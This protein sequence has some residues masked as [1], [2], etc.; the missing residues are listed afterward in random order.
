M[1]YPEPF[2]RPDSSYYWFEY[3]TAD[4]SRKRRSTRRKKKGEARDEIRRFIDSRARR[5]LS[6]PLGKYAEPFFDWDRCPRIKRLRQEGKTVGQSYAVNQRLFVTRDLSGDEIAYI[7][8][9]E[10]TRGDVLRYRDRLIDTYGYSVVVNNAIAALRAILKEAV[11]LEY[12]PTDPTTGITPIAVRKRTKHVLT[13]EQARTLFR[14]P[15]GLF[16]DDT[17][18]DMAL[19]MLTCG[20]RTQEVR[21]LM[22]EDID[23]T[24]LYIRRAFKYRPIDKT[25]EI[26]P[27]KNGKERW[28]Y[29][30]SFVYSRLAIRPPHRPLFHRSGV[31][32]NGRFIALRLTQ[33]LRR[34]GLPER[35]ITPHALRH[36]AASTLLGFGAPAVGVQLALGWSD[37]FGALGALG[38][39]QTNYTQATEKLMRQVQEAADRMIYEIGIDTK[40]GAVRRPL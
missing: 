16:T 19:V 13:I 34:A 11:F 20:L 1:R 18:Y 25:W 29:L 35:L 9:N 2:R 8:I 30:P 6:I 39:M 33:A 10:I 38:A 32:I 26:G 4:G 23:G 14:D 31:P 36:F 40:K 15:P 37:G 12:I 17:G 21:A 5:D 24:R 22:P 3:R 27:T 7:P 28:L